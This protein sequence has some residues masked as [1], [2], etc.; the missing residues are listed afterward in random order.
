MYSR[1]SEQ[2]WIAYTMHTVYNLHIVYI[3]I[4]YQCLHIVIV[5][6]FTGEF[7][8]AEKICLAYTQKSDVEMSSDAGKG[9]KRRRTAPTRY[10]YYF[11]HNNSPT[12][13]ITNVY[14]TLFLSAIH[15]LLFFFSFLYHKHIYV[16]CIVFWSNSFNKQV[17]TI[18]TYV[19]GCY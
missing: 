7:Q 12:S 3:Y 4:I 16:Y 2:L 11:H 13:D 18:T 10:R 19:M 14:S 1:Q 15:K 5:L 17:S 9:K 6:Y 8:K